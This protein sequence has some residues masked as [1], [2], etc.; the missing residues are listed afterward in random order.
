MAPQ[1][2]VQLPQQQ[3]DVSL[4]VPLP[5]PPPTRPVA[6]HLLA[7]APE[8]SPGK[9]LAQ[10]FLL[11]LAAAL[12]APPPRGGAGGSF[13]DRLA[14]RGAEN[15]AGGGTAEG[16]GGS[17][18]RPPSSGRAL[19][20]SRIPIPRPAGYLTIPPGL[21]PTTLFDSSPVLLP[22]S[23]SEPSPTTGTFPL[24][25]STFF[26]TSSGFPKPIMAIDPSSKDKSTADQGFVFKPVPQNA[27]SRLAGRVAPSSSALGASA[28][29]PLVPTTMPFSV[30]LNVPNFQAA[31]VQAHVQQQQ[32][33]TAPDSEQNSQASEQDHLLPPTSMT[34]FPERPSE[35]GYNWRKYGQ[36]QVK[37]SEYTR[38]YYKCTQANC[39]MK[40]KVERSHDGQVTEI[41]YKGEH[42]H[43]KPQPT[44]RLALNGFVSNVKN[45]GGGVEQDV[46]DSS[47]TNHVVSS[48]SFGATGAPE[49]LSPSTSDDEGQEGSRLSAE[50]GDDD[51]P[52]SKRRRKD[53]KVQ[54]VV[55]TSSRTIREP[56]VVVQ[57]T[58][59]VDI[60]DDGYRWRKYG[61]KVVKG[62]PHP[63]SYYKCT[64]V[65]CPV[66]KHVERAST[67]VKA[68]ITTYEG[69]H[70]HDVP[71][72]RNS[73]ND[74]LIQTTTPA[75]P[76]ATSLQD[77]GSQFNHNLG[78]LLDDGSCKVEISAEDVDLGVRSGMGAN[79]D[80][81]VS[82]SL[83]HSDFR[84][85]RVVQ[86]RDSF[87]HRATFGAR[88]KQEQ[89][90]STSQTT[91]I[92]SCT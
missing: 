39:P 59:D 1:K 7:E 48:L 75:V 10:R 86:G 5:V 55:P 92:P 78:Q 23:Q 91:L 82:T 14:A 16:G 28:R 17:A 20:P 61:Q 50:D 74:T 45:E 47:R 43:A 41:V 88:P 58:S 80:M 85:G 51:E 90:E 35:D 18:P 76:A 32:Q 33:Q 21:S 26:N 9:L 70:N 53:K 8:I 25:V 67:D 27:M 11:A 49:P 68:V 29:L 64:N 83:G 31:H 79:G 40:K 73:S 30:P 44:R 12:T 77:Q 52:D 15:T 72:A 65:G 87:V 3:A 34:A 69:K 57:T 84:D 46:M 38:S 62:N 89:P 19:P 56:R 6:A 37:G 42:N 81:P 71:S 66:R 60:L 54:E 4:P 13:T 36:K 22:T 24:G 2:K 63:R